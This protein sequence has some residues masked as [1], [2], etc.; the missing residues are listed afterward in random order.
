[1]RDAKEKLTRAVRPAGL[2]KKERASFPD[3]V[4]SDS[5]KIAEKVKS[6]G[7]IDQPEARSASF[8]AF[9]RRVLAL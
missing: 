3:Y 2:K 9:R 7:L 4:E 5:P 1:V 6:M 8:D